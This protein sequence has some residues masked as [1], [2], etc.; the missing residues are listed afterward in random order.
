MKTTYL[1]DKGSGIMN[2]DS[3]LITSNLFGIFDGATG[4]IKYTDSFGNT[5]GF[6]ASQIAKN[7]F[8]R[9]NDKPLLA[10]I[11]EVSEELSTKM[12]QNHVNLKD[13]GVAWTTSASVVRINK[14]FIEYI[15][16][17]DSPIVFLRKDGSIQTFIQDHDLETL[18]LWKTLVSEGMINIRNNKRMEEQLLKT[19]RESNITHGVLNGDLEALKFITQGSIPKADVETILIFSDGM[20][21]PQENPNKPEDFQE[22]VKLFKTGGLEKVKNFV[23]KIE[24]SD[25]QCLKYPRFKQHDDLTAIAISFK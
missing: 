16:L 13:T 1:S 4:L 8:E 11:Q 25:S 14:D 9:N 23:R 15:Q 6:L 5:G 24:N 17:G 22:I 2:E 3:F 21:I 19:R 12:L 10:S 20:L 7:V 18:N